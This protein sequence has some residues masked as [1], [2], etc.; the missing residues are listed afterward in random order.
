MLATASVIASASPQRASA[1]PAPEPPAALPKVGDDELGP[2]QDAIKDK[3]DPL[4][5]AL[6]PQPGGLTFAQVAREAIAGS[7]NVR[8]KEAELEGAE[9]A[10]AQSMVTFFPRLTLAASYTRISDTASG[11]LG[12][13]A[14]VGA[15]NEGLL[16]VGN[17]PGNPGAQCVVDAAG[18]PVQATAFDLSTPVLNQYAFS[19]NLTIPIS[20]YF[21]RAVQAYSAAEHSENALS[22]AAEAQRLAV[23]AEAKITMLSWVLA[24]GQTIVTQRSVDQASNQLKDARSLRAADKGSNADVMRIEA[25]V[26]Q[27]QFTVAE[28]AALEV[29]AEERLRIVLRAPAD[30]PLGIGVDVFSSPAIPVMTTSDSLVAE[31]LAARLEI[32]SNEETRKAY[33]D[34]ESTTAAGFWPR[35]DG[36]GNVLIANPNQRIF[37]QREQ[38]D[39]TWDLGV[40]L[41]WTVND[42]FSTLG[43]SSQARAR[44]AQ[45]SAQKQLLI[46]AVRLEVV[47][48]HADVLKA[49]PSIEAAHRGVIAAE[50]ALRINQLLFAVGSGTGTALADAENAVTSARLRKL[51]AHVGLHAALVRLEHATGRDRAAPLARR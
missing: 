6:A 27:A 51:S 22:M 30:R 21:L 40:R 49:A 19:A 10:V 1:Q 5:L 29:V 33:E 17:C 9:G 23:A 7:A 26:A 50:E 42:T 2:G 41:T 14:L 12:G 34:I 45:V 48:A 8:A 38:F 43:A 31:A 3:P 36:V 25:L 15:L 20:D 35:L 32:L 13:G 28:A 47:Q 24:R 4:V 18:V 16:G 46:D 37:P 44:T 39:A 11:S